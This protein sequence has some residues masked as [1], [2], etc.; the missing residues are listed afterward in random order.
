MKE[1]GTV[2]SLNG[3][4]STE[5]WFVVNNHQAYKGQFIQL[6]TG[7]GL[8]IARIEEVKKSNRYY[9][10]AESVSEYEKSGKPLTEQFPVSRWECLIAKA[11]PLGVYVN[12]EQ[13]RVVFP[14]SPGEKVYLAEWDVLMDFFGFDGSGINLGKM[15]FHELEVKLNLTRLFQK[16]LAILA[17]SGAGKSYLASVLIEELLDRPKELGKPAIIVVD[18]HGEYLGF[19]EDENYVAKTRVWRAKNISI[20]TSN[21][22][23][24]EIAELIP[25]MSWVQR[26]E[27]SPLI[28]EL[29][30][31]K[32]NYS[33]EDLIKTVEESNMNPKTKYA[34]LSW[35]NELNST[36]LFRNINSPSIEELAVAG[37][38]S[39]LDLSDV[40]RLR[41]KQIIVT[42]FTRQLFDARRNGRIPPFIFILEEAHQFV[43][44]GES[45]AE[46]I[47]R[48]VIEQIAREGRKFGACLV[49]IS[50]R[51]IKLSTT[52]LSQCNTHIILR[53]TNPYDLDHISKSSEGITKDVLKMI[54]GLKVGEALI[55]GEAVNY[56]VLVKVRKRR[57]RKSE[58]GVKL[59]DALKKYGSDKEKYLDDLKGF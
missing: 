28:R 10:R 39:I 38:L 34:L 9:M 15:E 7:D 44:E 25:Q 24:S 12:G 3:P 50:Q 2:I 5:F 41:E 35:L 59:E 54:P 20:A 31:R 49:L 30:K 1:L 11:C 45:R 47:S 40:I 23:V 48:G 22:S 29:K 8:L 19:A 46:A 43:P 21:L 33:F 57:S 4:T 13:K 55:V 56:P 26:R 32:K 52:A 18:P 53:V 16:H 58:K 51:P 27:L 36:H 42:Y 37:R 14:P 17:I 6:Q